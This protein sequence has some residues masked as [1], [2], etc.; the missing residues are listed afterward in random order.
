MECDENHLKK[1]LAGL[2]E[3]PSRIVYTEHFLEKT[4]QRNIADVFVEDKLMLEKPKHVKKIENRSGRF[5]LCYSWSDEADLIVV[6]DVL[7]VNS[8]VLVSALPKRIDGGD[9]SEKA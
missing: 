5:E 9:G 6:L 3:D 7:L 4:E 2:A 1:V 8:V